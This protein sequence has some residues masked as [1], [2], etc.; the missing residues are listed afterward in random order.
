MPE[1]KKMQNFVVGFPIFCSSGGETRQLVLTSAN[2]LQTDTHTGKSTPNSDAGA[3]CFISTGDS[4]SG[5]GS[6]N[7]QMSERVTAAFDSH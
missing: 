5:G 4:I 7:W 1:S 2:C 3:F 6:G